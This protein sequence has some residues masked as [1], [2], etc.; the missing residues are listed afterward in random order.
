MARNFVA[1]GRMLLLSI[2]SHKRSV[3]L[4]SLDD[5]ALGIRSVSRFVTLPLA[6][7][8]APIMCVISAIN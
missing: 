1:E 5:G 2:Q 4:T 3:S 8:A 7:C 6:V